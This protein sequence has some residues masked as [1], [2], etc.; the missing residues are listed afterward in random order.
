MTTLIRHYRMFVLGMMAWTLFE[1]GAF[2]RLAQHVENP[3]HQGKLVSV[4]GNELVMKSEDGQEHSHTLT[5]DACLTLDDKTCHLDDLKPGTQIRVTTE[6]EDL[7]AA[8][9]IEAI[10]EKGELSFRQR[11]P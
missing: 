2:S 6:V 9:R 4:A 7:T 3:T 11:L 8:I 10:N 1:T 5:A